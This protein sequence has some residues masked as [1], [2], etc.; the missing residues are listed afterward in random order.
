MGGAIDEGRDSVSLFLG[1]ELIVAFV[2][3]F[4]LVR[5]CVGPSVGD[6]PLEVDPRM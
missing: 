5:S 3:V 2:F 4:A 1:V 6:D